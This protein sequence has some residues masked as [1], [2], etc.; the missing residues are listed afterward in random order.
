MISTPPPAIASPAL[1]HVMH[2]FRFDIAAPLARAA[3]LFGPDGERA[4]GGP[5]WQ[6]SF[7]FP[8]HAQDVEGAVFTVPH[9][10]G[11]AV[12]V[13]TI[14][15]LAGGHMQYVAFIPSAMVTVVDVRLSGNAGVTT[16][17][18]TYTRTALD[19]AMNDKV[20]ALGE[21]DAA[22]G[23]EWSSAIADALK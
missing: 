19:P 4:W 2:S 10:D 15:D 6:P 9:G 5:T 13:N 22:S 21:S 23:P 12:W 7:L 18:V 20:T 16:A 17:D 1:S 8:E 14:F 3:P 11:T